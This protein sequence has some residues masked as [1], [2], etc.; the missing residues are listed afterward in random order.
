M[1]RYPVDLPVRPERVPH[2][3]GDEPVQVWIIPA[4]QGV[5]HARGDETDPRGEKFEDRRE[6]PMHVGMNR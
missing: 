6:F 2:A 1:N 4:S 5:P 3:R